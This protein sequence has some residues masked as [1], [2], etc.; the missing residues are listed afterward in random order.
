[1]VVFTLDSASRV[2]MFSGGRGMFDMIR[3]DLG[4]WL[5]WA[6]FVPTVLVNI[7]VNM[8]QSSAMIEG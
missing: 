6:L 7:I 3:T 1:M 4:A 5:A 8:S 2:A